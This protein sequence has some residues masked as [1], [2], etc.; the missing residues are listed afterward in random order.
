MYCSVD[1]PT[2]KHTWSHHTSCRTVTVFLVTVVLQEH[3]KVLAE[4]LAALS[5]FG[6]D[7]STWNALARTTCLCYLLHCADISNSV[8]PLD[9]SAEWAKRVNEG[10]CMC[11]CVCVVGMCVCVAVFAC[12]LRVQ[13]GIRG[14][15]AFGNPSA[16]F[17]LLLPSCVLSPSI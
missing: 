6:P 13:L 8:K 14:V 2:S 15:K 12:G 4:L 11:V 3:K 17:V 5:L 7:L 10:G 9:L 16:S 1:T